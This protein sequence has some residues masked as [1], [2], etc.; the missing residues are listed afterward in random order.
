MQSPS[1]VSP[2]APVRQVVFLGFLD[3]A[4]QQNHFIGDNAKQYPANFSIRHI[5]P[6]FTKSVAERTADW[7]SNR[8]T[9]LNRWRPPFAQTNSSPTSS[10]WDAA[11]GGTCP[12]LAGSGFFWSLVWNIQTY[13]ETTARCQALYSSDGNAQ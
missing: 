10:P 7:H 11:H 1:F 12:K 8:P 4:V 2:Q 13:S 6:H 5:T 3:E 9:K